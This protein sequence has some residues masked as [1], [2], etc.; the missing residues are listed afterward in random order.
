MKDTSQMQLS[1]QRDEKI[2][3]T[4]NREKHKKNP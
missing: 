1:Q 3:A 4:Q 2:L